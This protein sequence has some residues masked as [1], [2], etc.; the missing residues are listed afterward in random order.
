[1]KHISIKQF[2]KCLKC[3]FPSIRYSWKDDCLILEGE[4]DTW[5]SI[6]DAGYLAAKVKSGGVINNICL[7]DYIAP[8]M[9]QSSLKDYLYDG[10]SPDVLIIG[11]GV[12]GCA[13][14]REFTKYKIDAVLV[15]KENDVA[16][17]ASSHNDGCIHVGAD[18][19]VNSKK[20]QYLRRAVPEFDQLSK[21]LGFDYIK[22]G[23]TVVF[24]NAFERLLSPILRIIFARKGNPDMQIWGKKRLFEAAPGVNKTAKFALHFPRG[25][26]V[27]PYNVTIAFA[28]NAI[29]NG[30]TILLETAVT[31]MDVV[32]HQII[33]V[34]TN[35]GIF[36]PKIIVNAAGVYSDIVAKLADDQFFTIHPRKGLDV[37]LDKKA[38]SKLSNT[39]LSLYESKK[40]RGKSHTKGGGLVP[41]TDGNILVGP[42]ATEIKEREDFSTESSHLRNVIEKHKQVTPGLAYSDVITYFSGIRAATYE[43]DFVVCPG[44]WTKNIVH[45]AGIQS[46]GLTAAPAIAVDIVKYVQDLLGNKLEINPNFNP[47]RAIKKPMRLLSSE[48][49]NEAIKKN[50]DYGQIVCRCEEISRGEIIDALNRPLPVNTIDGIKRRIRPGMGRCQGGFCQPLVLQIISET[51]GIKLTDI[52]KK[53]NGQ[54]LLSDSKGNQYG[55]I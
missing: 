24:E 6:V 7:K 5:E 36:Y 17:H 25:G 20:F 46:P 37:I 26:I 48:E 52:K 34:H 38:F 44:K 54:V 14:L 2:A 27:S 1:M 12:V 45:A 30:G 22:T 39:T 19:H 47:K 33:A 4:L 28:E 29:E 32:N 53:G 31:H 51:Q 10:L 42:T 16:L 50:P 11:G 13:I 43:E 15:E 23:Q 21:D 9:R 55:D 35:R 3:S 18:L 49:R 40:S 41:T 8:E